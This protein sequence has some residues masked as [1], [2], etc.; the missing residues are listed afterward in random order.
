MAVDD[1]RDACASGA[2]KAGGVAWLVSDGNVLASAEVAC[3]RAERKRGLLG[4]DAMEGALVIDKCRWIHTLG[5]RFP[6]DV[7]Y[8]DA[9]GT[10]IKAVRMERNRVGAPVKAATRVLEA[11]A[12]AF[13]RWGLHVGLTVELRS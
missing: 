9:D 3:N 6:L 1:V 12:G 13:A 7:A 4:R 5:M 8:L 2:C 11:E 10:V